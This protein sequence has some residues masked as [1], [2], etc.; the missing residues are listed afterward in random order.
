[1][2]DRELSKEQR[3]LRVLRKVLANIVKDATPAPGTPHPLSESTI[4][5]IR[6]LF[7]LIAER[8][9][10]LAA[11]AV[12]TERARVL[13]ILA[14]DPDNRHL[15][16]LINAIEAGTPAASI[17]KTLYQEERTF[18]QTG[19]KTL[20]DSATPS[21]GQSRQDPPDTAQKTFFG[22]VEAAMATHNMTKAQAVRHVQAS[23]PELHATFLTAQK[24]K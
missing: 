13:E 22:E 24:N 21:V 2:T 4:H 16:F 18:R 6:D 12:A 19:L 9:A 20:A 17:F 3:I 15:A 8:E 23:M 1:M 7:G 11:E 10:E 5:D 14:A